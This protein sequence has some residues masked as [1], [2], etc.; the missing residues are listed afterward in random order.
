MKVRGARTAASKFCTDP[1]RFAAVRH[2][3]TSA[4]LLLVSTA[5]LAAAPVKEIDTTGL[6]GRVERLERLLESRG[7]VDMLAQLEALQS[8]VNRLR[9]ELEVQ[10][11]ALEDLRKRQ[12]DLYADLDARLRRLESGAPAADA[13]PAAP[14]SAA[15][16]PLETLSPVEVDE[17]MSPSAVAEADAGLTVELVGPAPA[18]TAGLAAPPATAVAP[19]T[20]P[21]DAAAPQPMS[22]PVKARADYQQAFNLLKQSLYAQAIKAFHEFLAQHPASEYADDAQYWLGEAHYVTRD[23]EAALPEYQK[24][25][26]GY[27]ES[28]KLTQA[29]LKI[30]YTLQELGRIDEAR[31]TLHDLA[32]RYPSTSA[33]RLA[34]ERLATLPEAAGATSP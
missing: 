27:P 18:P 29:L 20:T 1:V 21:V 8:E 12:R 31:N 14:D 34:E 5:A 6:A 9:G 3:P 11:H 10:T 4:F 28:Q 32:R 16:P 25:V 30:G 15:G 33:A 19:V 22:D 13:G 17:E 26:A 7:L 23:F 24:L 2:C